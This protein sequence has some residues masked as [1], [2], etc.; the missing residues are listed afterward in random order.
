MILTL[1]LIVF[2]IQFLAALF[3]RSRAS[4]AIPSDKQGLQ[5]VS[6]IIPFHNEENR[7]SGLLKAL[8]HAVIPDNVEVL[9][10][11]D[12]STDNSVQYVEKSL[13]ILYRIVANTVEKGKKYAIRQGVKNAKYDHVL[14]LDAD[15]AFGPDFL[16]RIC[17]LPAED[18]IVLPVEMKGRSLL[19][20]LASIEFGFLQRLTFALINWGKP[21]LC[22]GANLLFNKARFFD[23]DVNRTDY[24]IPSGDDLFL[25][26][27]FRNSGFGIV[28]YNQSHLR[29]SSYAPE[30]WK[31]LLGQRK[32]WMGK[33]NGL[34]T[35]ELSL[36][37]LLLLAT[38]L[39]FLLICIASFT[40]P[41]LAILLLLKFSSELITV[42]EK[43]L[44]TIKLLGLVLLHQFWY[45]FYLIMAIIPA[46][47]DDRWRVS[48]D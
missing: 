28:G 36:A 6:I 27:E 35:T 42:W 48:K 25:L 17:Q 21:A 39:M 31:S 3:I 20:S 44:G 29:V 24:T 30:T 16:E 8:N 7:I 45:P 34:L 41:F 1:V 9:F 26:K 10:V 5:G 40:Q 14:T 2:G 32:R 22:N 37:G 33:M 47:S 4:I 23:V 11:D 18:M 12:H 19:A 38:Q 46:Q 13:D 43:G 15:V